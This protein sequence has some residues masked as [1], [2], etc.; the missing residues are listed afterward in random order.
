MKCDGENVKTPSLAKVCHNLVR[1]GCS[2]RSPL[3]P[4]P[5]GLQS[6]SPVLLSGG[7]FRLHSGCL[8]AQKTAPAVKQTILHGAFDR[9]PGKRV[10][11]SFSPTESEIFET[12]TQRNL[13]F[14]ACSTTDCK[15]SFDTF[16]SDHLCCMEEPLGKCEDED[17]SQKR[18]KIF[19]DVSS[20]AT[21]VHRSQPGTPSEEGNKHCW[22]TPQS[23][24]AAAPCSRALFSGLPGHLAEDR[25]GSAVALVHAEDNFKLSGGHMAGDG[26]CLAANRFVAAKQPEACTKM[27]VWSD[28]HVD[29]YYAGDVG[30]DDGGDGDGGDDEDDG[31]ESAPAAHAGRAKCRKRKQ[32]W[33]EDEDRRLRSALD[34]Y[35]FCRKVD[36][37]KVAAQLVGRT[38]K[39][40]RERWNQHLS[41]CVNKKAWSDSEDNALIALVK[42]HGTQWVIIAKAL[43]TSRT[44]GAVKNRYIRLHKNGKAADPYAAA[45]TTAAGSSTSS[46]AS[47]GASA[48]TGAA[49]NARARAK[50]G[51]AAREGTSIGIGSAVPT[52]QNARAVQSLE[53]ATD[54]E[55]IPLAEFADVWSCNY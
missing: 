46:S 30:E 41:P 5:N 45:S 49:A 31:N 9:Q 12:E 19:Q 52:S 38:S 39:Q 22:R 44:D 1:V 40:C 35:I 25:G 33:G 3:G 42:E 14:S 28:A 50:A 13:A 15:D 4:L 55:R 23:E 2:H 18:R 48:I 8:S 24:K 10:S 20:S 32:V 53:S 21:A 7:Q 17:M 6:R 36:W 43:N 29:R 51:A 27:E 37:K 47:A 34:D 16:L 11:F 54:V 26:A